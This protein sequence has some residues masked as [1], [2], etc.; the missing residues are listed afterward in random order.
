MR[1]DGFRELWEETEY[2][3]DAGKRQKKQGGQRNPE[4]GN[5][6]G[7]A[8]WRTQGAKCRRRTSDG[9]TASRQ[10]RGRA[11]YAEADQV[12]GG[13][14]PNQFEALKFRLF[15]GVCLHFLDPGLLP[16]LGVGL[17][18]PPLD[19][20]LNGIRRWATACPLHRSNDRGGGGVH[21]SSTPSPSFSSTPGPRIVSSSSRADPPDLQSSPDPPRGPSPYYVPGGGRGGTSSG[22][23]LPV[24]ARPLHFRLAGQAGW[25]GGSRPPGLHPQVS[26]QGGA[27]H[28]VPSSSAARPQGSAAGA[29]SRPPQGLSPFFQP[30]AHAI[31]SAIG[32]ASAQSGALRSPSCFLFLGSARSPCGHKMQD[33]RFFC[34]ARP[35]RDPGS[36]GCPKRRLSAILDRANYGRMTEGSRALSECDRHLDARSHAQ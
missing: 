32:L 27:A 23:G 6:R 16:A 9:K 15:W 18:K 33:L 8:G 22:G 21:D 4:R 26:A 35:P 25:M 11:T 28:L 20:D 14:W 3:E 5:R 31:S 34:R 1:H 24:P 17:G 7:D 29:R 2:P 13:A 19:G 12:P 36:Q 10:Q 30:A